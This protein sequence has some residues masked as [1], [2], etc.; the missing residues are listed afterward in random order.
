M[1]SL[2]HRRRCSDRL[3]QLVAK[4]S[5]EAASTRLLDTIWAIDNGTED[6]H[7]LGVTVCLVGA[8][9]HMVVDEE[10]KENILE[11]VEVIRLVVKGEITP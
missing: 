3:R 2:E 10:S 9:Y 4:T 7:F 5:S 11:L 6:Y 8:T 1:A